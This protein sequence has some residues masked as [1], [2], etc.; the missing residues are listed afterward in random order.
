MKY[1]LFI[2][3]V[4]MFGTLSIFAQQNN[5]PIL[6][7]VGNENIP[8]SEFT[9]IYL[10]NNQAST[11]TDSK[12]VEEYLNLF[13]NFKLKVADALSIKLD[14]SSTFKN[15]LAGYRLQL[16]RP[17]MVDKET[18]QRLI[19]E[20]YERMKYEVSASHILINVPEKATPSDTL[21]LYEKA[22]A[23]RNRIVNG[24]SFDVVARATSDDHSV[25]SNN[26]FLGY[27]TA[28]QMVYPFET[29]VYNL[30]PNE[31]SMPIRTRYGYHIIK[32]LDKRPAKGQVKIAHIMIAV[33]KD[34][35]PE[36]QSQAKE[37]IQGIYKQVLNNEDFG[38][39]AGQYSQDPGSAKNN[40]ELP[41]FSSGMIIPEI[42]N[43]AFGFDHDGQVSE[44][45]Q[46][47][48]GWHIAKR[49]GKKEVGTFEEMLPE[50]K[51][52]LSSD[53]RSTISIEK[54]ISKIK[55]ENGFK[56]DTVNI[57][58]VVNLLD[59][60]VLKGSWKIPTLHENK[61]IFVFAGQNHDQSEFAKFIFS[62]QQKPLY[63]SFY[64]IV[65]NAYKDWVNKTVYD[66]QLST[67]EQKYPDFKN[68]MK[69]YHDGNLLFG[70]SEINVWSKASN[71]SVGLERFY[72]KNKENYRW[73]ERI[74]YAVYSCTDEQLLSKAN[75]MVLTRKSKG[76]KPEN[77]L[78]KLNQNSQAKVDLAYMIASSDDLDVI[79]YK[80]WASG[81]S[82]ISNTKGTYTF[83]EFL[84]LTKGDIKTL[85]D[86]KGQ[87]IA[88][89]QQ[90]LEEEW[91]KTL[92]EKY[93]VSVNQEVLK[94]VI[95][96]LVKK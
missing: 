14:T 59:S 50:I 76:I 16:A 85:D 86:C 19:A 2:L 53:S 17:Y 5:D 41:W 57:L 94:S 35:T 43:V 34:A 79:D 1:R 21:K 63:G 96:T 4:V 13:I 74:Q 58:P 46:T 81:V 38:K 23:I 26:G 83:K 18:E 11:I 28:F 10:K 33:N 93:P 22:I 39:L 69:E 9:R 71:D 64:T 87:V 36:Q 92:H 84:A 47:S 7:T 70:I 56:E 8:A 65:K 32:V 55:N 42:E 82:S 72:Q 88:D 15:E 20:A 90:N 30:K 49:I 77:I 3:S 68:L 52:K 60:S 75:K 12:S 6:L 91:L 61:T 27:F 95:N 80:S 89:Y 37:K 31:I 67:L 29:A 73:G 44:P 78:S 45:F 25:T 66:Y 40:G 51:K 54:M 48:Y 62:Y 24:E